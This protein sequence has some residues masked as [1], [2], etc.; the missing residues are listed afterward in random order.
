MMNISDFGCNLKTPRVMTARKA[1]GNLEQKP[2][3][4]FPFMVQ[5]MISWGIR[6]SI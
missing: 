6:M 1:G 2:T 3:K 4:Q 5:S